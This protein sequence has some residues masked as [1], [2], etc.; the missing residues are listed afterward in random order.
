MKRKD[1]ELTRE[2]AL[3]IVDRCIYG[4]VSAVT[5]EGIP[6]AVPVDLVRDGDR[7]YFHCAH[8]GLKTDCLRHEPRVCVTFVDSRAEIDQPGLTTLYASA[9]V[10]ADAS[11]ITDKEEKIR[12][13]HLLCQRFAPEHPRSSGDFSECLSITAV[14]QLQIKEITGKANRGKQQ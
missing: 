5:P 11:E 13:L 3:E 7:L 6:Y 12:A 8:T 10:N 4:V 2:Q 14:W 1:R 9:I